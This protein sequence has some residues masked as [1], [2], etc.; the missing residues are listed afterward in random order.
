[1]VQFLKVPVSGNQMNF[2]N[3]I[4]PF[5]NPPIVY[6]NTQSRVSQSVN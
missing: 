5:K 6:D 2:E 1:M 4:I 3:Q